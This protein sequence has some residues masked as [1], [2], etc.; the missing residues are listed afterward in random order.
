MAPQLLF[1]ALNAKLLFYHS[2]AD[3]TVRTAGI[4]HPGY[5]HSFVAKQRDTADVPSTKIPLKGCFVRE[6]LQRDSGSI[7]RTFQFW[8][9]LLIPWPNVMQMPLWLLQL[10]AILLEVGS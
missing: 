2:T 1:L 8:I 3:L 4:M 9:A 10:I 6:R 7:R 5:G